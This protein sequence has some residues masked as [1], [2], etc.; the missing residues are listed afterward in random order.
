MRVRRV[1]TPPPLS[2][3]D[4]DAA[5]QA[6]VEVAGAALLVFSERRWH[7]NDMAGRAYQMATNIMSLEGELGPV[8]EETYSRRRIGLMATFA[9]Q[10]IGMARREM[11]AGSADISAL[12]DPSLVDPSIHDTLTRVRGA[13]FKPS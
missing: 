11:S 10:L 12:R 3:D 8:D 9:H 2:P 1:G 5:R 13:G 7:L 4:F 6:A